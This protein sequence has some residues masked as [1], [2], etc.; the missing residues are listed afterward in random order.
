MPDR[1]QVM[2]GV[3]WVPME[4]CK[5]CEILRAKLDAVRMAWKGIRPYGVAWTG[6]AV[7]DMEAA[8]DDD[9]D[10]AQEQLEA[11]TA[12]VILPDSDTPCPSCGY[13]SRDQ[14]VHGDHH[15]CDGPGW[16]NRDGEPNELL[17]HD[18]PISGDG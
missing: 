5:D 18:E 16:Q 17:D 11:E 6:T 15:L 10:H 12:M 4:P 7:T 2:P 14:E 1:D 9:R 13:T 8:L 3:D